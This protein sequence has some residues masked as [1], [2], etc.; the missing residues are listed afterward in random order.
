[1]GA[2][3]SQWIACSPTRNGGG[4]RPLNSVVRLLASTVAEFRVCQLTRPYRFESP[5]LRKQFVAWIMSND[6][7]ITADERYAIS[8]D[9]VKAGCRYAVCSGPDGTLWDDSVDFA[10]LEV[11]PDLKDDEFVMTTWHDDETLE[12]I[13]FYFTQNT[14]FGDFVPEVF[15]LV[16]VGPS[17]EIL[18]A[19]TQV[20]QFLNA[21]AI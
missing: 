18:E 1:V 13:A 5:V 15:I 19:K 11:S 12:D 6:P 8:L 20:E 16:A 3:C 21:R 2:S 7:T 4:G 17:K 10:N 9:L 14:A